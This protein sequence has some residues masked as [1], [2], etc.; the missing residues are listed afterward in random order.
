MSAVK[1]TKT[2]ETRK[3]FD[4]RPSQAPVDYDKLISTAMT[5][6]PKVHAILAK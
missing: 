2:N 6:F 3:T 1:V 4:V 5:R